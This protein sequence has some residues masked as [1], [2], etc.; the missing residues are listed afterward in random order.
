[1]HH[2]GKIKS[3]L[4]KVKSF[5]IQENNVYAC[6][7]FPNKYTKKSNESSKYYIKRSTKSFKL[8]ECDALPLGASLLPFERA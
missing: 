8:L 4:I 1:V 2:C 3:A 6:S 5:T 7:V